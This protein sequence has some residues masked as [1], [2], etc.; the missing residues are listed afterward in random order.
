MS[1]GNRTA[2]PSE[3]ICPGCG[4]FAMGTP[5]DEPVPE[6]AVCVF[7]APYDPEREGFAIL[8]LQDA[9]EEDLVRQKPKRLGAR[10]PQKNPEIW[11]KP[12]H[13]E[14]LSKQVDYFFEFQDFLATILDL[15][16]EGAPPGSPLGRTRDFSKEILDAVSARVDAEH[17]KNPARGTTPIIVSGV[18]FDRYHAILDLLQ[19]RYLIAHKK[20][21]EA[22]PD[23][24]QARKASYT[25]FW[26]LGSLVRTGHLAESMSP[27]VTGKEKPRF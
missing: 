6:D 27:W 7:C 1:L 12:D 15:L 19:S 25:H 26:N 20:F 16:Y 11:R 10:D 14:V 3:W 24:E 8:L 2:R 5:P 22:Q 18:D 13:L 21:L 4:V 9:L 17:R 23:K